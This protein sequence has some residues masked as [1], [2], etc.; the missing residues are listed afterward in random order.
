MKKNFVKLS[1]FLCLIFAA[2][3]SISQTQSV[4][5]EAS[6]NITNFSFTDS[7]GNKDENYMPSYS[8]SYALG[9]KYG[10]DDLGLF[11]TGKL[12]MRK[13]GATYV[14]DNM[15]YSWDLQYAEARLGVGYNYSFDKF[16]AHLSV[17][18]YYGYLL[19]ANQR[20]NNEDF[21]IR[22]SGSLNT[23]DFGL[24]I[25]PGVNFTAS[26]AISIYLDVNYMM[27]LANLETDQ[28]QISKNSLIGASLGVAFTIK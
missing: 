4:T 23:N 5:I 9:Y 15:N 14:Y 12:G 7:Q 1:A 22:N 6:Q 8:G 27:G 26:D 19:K 3:T 17:Q 13:G 21:D 25:S 2:S 11:F 24:F 28:S 20:L 18:G 10:M 16:G